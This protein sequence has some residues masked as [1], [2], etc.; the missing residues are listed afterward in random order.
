MAEP[1]IRM[2]LAEAQVGLEDPSVLEAATANLNEVVRV[3]PKNARA[4]HLLATAYGRAGNAP[5]ADLAQ[6]EEYLARGKKK[7]AKRFADRALQGLPEGS[8]GWLKAQDIQFAADQGE[9]D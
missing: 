1:L 4:F 5:M 7:D 3:E 2:E 8:P 9:D 6:A